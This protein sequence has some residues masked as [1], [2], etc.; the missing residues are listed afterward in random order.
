MK[1]SALL[2]GASLALSAASAHAAV[3][4]TLVGPTAEVASPGAISE[5]FAAGGGAGQLSFTIKAFGSLDGAN[6]PDGNSDV[7]TLSLNGADIL[8]GSWD[9]GGGGQNVVFFAPPGTTAVAQS[10]SFAGGTLKVATSLALASGT[11]TLKFAFATANPK[12]LN[13]EGWA[14]QDVSVTGAAAQAGVP[15]P[16][17]WALLVA[18]FLASGAAV[19]SARRRPAAA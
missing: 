17:T 19:R 18:G 5:A 16:A 13:D 14:L 3:L 9:L 15:E 10:Q 6:V 12:G 8:S 7:F 4:F 1:L 11:N 2:A